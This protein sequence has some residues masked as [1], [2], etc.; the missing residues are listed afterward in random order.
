MANEGLKLGDLGLDDMDLGDAM[1]VIKILSDLEDVAMAETVMGTE[2]AVWQ[3][4]I[5]SFM[6][7][8]GHVIQCLTEDESVSSEKV[9]EEG[10]T[11]LFA[12]YHASFN[13]GAAMMGAKMMTY[14]Q[15]DD[16]DADAMQKYIEGVLSDHMSDHDSEE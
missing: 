7:V 15:D 13:M 16:I 2:A 14:A 1:A 4:Q 5:I 11:L 10:S 6:S 12:F 9:A 8:V 3:P